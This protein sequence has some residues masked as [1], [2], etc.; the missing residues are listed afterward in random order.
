MP[1]CGPLRIWHN[2][3]IIIIVWQCAHK[4]YQLQNQN[5][6]TM[7]RNQTV[8]ENLKKY[9]YSGVGFA[10]HASELF[11]NTMDESVKAGR[12]SESDG[13]KI[14]D[15]VLKKMEERKSG[16]EDK[17]NESLHK[18]I[19][20]SSDEISVLQKKVEKLEDQLKAKGTGRASLSQPKAA[21]KAA[22]KKV[23]KAVKKSAA[24]IK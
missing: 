5:I 8:A 11:K 17:Y 6:I 22:V 9:F 20:M 10:S 18:F 15:D 12:L 24:R 23:V 13:K 3:S 1:T 19:S 4:R 14:I 21:A 7:A 16:L 2:Y